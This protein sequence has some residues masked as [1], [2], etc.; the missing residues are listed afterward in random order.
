MDNKLLNIFK[1]GKNSHHIS[2]YYRWLDEIHLNLKMTFPQN[3]MQKVPVF[4]QK[5]S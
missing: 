4:H 3:I 2:S 1:N 5:K